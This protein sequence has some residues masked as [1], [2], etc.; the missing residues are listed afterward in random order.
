[1]NHN[2]NTD[3]IQ[4]SL[5][6]NGLHS[7]DRATDSFEKYISLQDDILLRD[8]V[9]FLH[10]AVELLLKQVL[11]NHSEYLIFEDLR[12]ATKKQRKAEEL[13]I[14]VFFLERS[15]RTV[16]FLEAVNRVQAFIKPQG[17]S[18]RLVGDLEKPNLVRNQLEH[19]AIDA[20]REEIIQLFSSIRKPLLDFFEESIPEVKFQA[21]S[22]RLR[23][24]V[25]TPAKAHNKLEWEV[26]N[27]LLTFNNQEIPGGLFNREGSIILPKFANVQLQPRI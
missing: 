2:Q 18:N 13:G 20:D 16:S 26:Y 19:Y 25:N 10:H 3:R 8:A 9:I 11:V 5:Y 24:A 17:L 14:A 21:T 15:P 22:E 23:K 6:A 4:I 7:L 27:T 1:M 12:D